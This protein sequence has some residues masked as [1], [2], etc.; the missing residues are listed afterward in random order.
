MS[1]KGKNRRNRPAHFFALGLTVFSIPAFAWGEGRALSLDFEEGTGYGRIIVGWE[2]SEADAPRINAKMTGPVLILKFEEPVSFDPEELKEGLPGYIAVARLTDDGREARVA[3]AREYRIHQ[4]YSFD[5]AGIDLVNP[6]L[7]GDPDDIVSPLAARKQR[8]AEEAAAA[9]EAARLAALPPALNVDVRA[10]EAKDFSTLAF[11]WPEDISFE[12]QDDGDAITVKFSRRGIADLAHARIDPPKG[13]TTLDAE[14]TDQQWIVRMGVEPGHWASVVKVDSAVL[15]R[16]REGEK[17]EGG[18]KEDVILPAALQ[19]LS[20]ALPE[21]PSEEDSNSILPPSRKPFQVSPLESSE[22]SEVVRT[23]TPGPKELRVNQ[24]S[25]GAEVDEAISVAPLTPRRL[26]NEAL[27]GAGKAQVTAVPHGGAVDIDISFQS[28]IPAAIFRRHKAVWIAFPASGEFD[29]SSTGSTAGLRIDQVNSEEGMA[30]RIYA[31]EDQLVSINQSGRLWSVSIGGKGNLA[32]VQLKPQRTASSGGSGILVNVP[33]IG[34][35]FDLFDPD[36]GETITAV[37]V[38]THTTSLDRSLRFVEAILPVTDQGLVIFPLADDLNVL[39][40]GEQVLISRDSGLAISNWGVDT[41]L[42][43]E[44]TLSPG[45]L[46]FAKWRRGDEGDFWR[47]HS[48]L[49]RAAALAHPEEWSGQSALMD[50]ARFYLAWG[51]A[52]ESYGPLT[53]LSEADPLLKEDAQWLALKGAADI[54][55]GRYDDALKTLDK[56]SIRSDA[57]VAAWR[58]YAFAEQGDWRK[59]REAFITADPMIDAYADIWAGRF[60]AAAARANIR[61]GDGAEAERHALAARRS[62]DEIAA[63]QAA[64]TLGEL[65]L[66]AGRKQDAASAFT[67][68]LD[69]KNGNIRVR[70]ELASINLAR[71]MGRMSDLDASDRLDTLRLR[72]RGDALELE[73]VNALVDVLFELGQFRE[74]LHLAQ[75]TTMQFPDMP[76]SRDLRI[77]MMDQFE[78]LYLDGRADDMDPIVSLALFYEFKD[79]TP[80]G[81]DGDRMIRKLANRLIAFDLLDPATELLAHQVENRNIVGAGKAKIASD[82]AAI[83]LMDDRPEEALR[84]IASTRQ[85]GIDDEVRLERRLLEAAA[86]MELNR[87]GHAIELL[88]G[89]SDQRALDLLAEVHWRSRTWGAAGRALHGTLPEAGVALTSQQAQ[90][91]LRAAI[92]YRLDGDYDGLTKLR[93]SYL[94]AMKQTSYAESFDL[95]TGTN[96]VSSVKLTDTIRTLADTSSADAFI[97]SLK[98]RFGE[99]GGMQ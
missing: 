59:S 28:E 36:V 53:L 14:N 34:T 5:L 87:F 80:I 18:A 91:A 70:A 31:P 49:D 12:E 75:S 94:G 82:L 96:E 51:L 43:S 33:D 88:D 6:V 60:H 3:L 71:E 17:P 1:L 32:N 45:F 92:A 57:A 73:I 11:Y 52:P 95:L 79:L 85:P 63:G 41:E 89:L 62:G 26:W 46:D 44:H 84:V 58:G 93:S 74:A 64:L 24:S 7:S 86:H 83:Y 55:N 37:S 65:A 8:E 69:H 40:R 76:G 54:M 72:W 38:K 66:A 78:K 97:R 67:K 23:E 15:V 4:S 39:Q 48:E 9:A 61:M 90:T 47:N 29:L 10:S 56:S 20:D 42:R 30:L 27:D 22:A 2:G 77:T 81:T 50:L 21:K 35:V 98:E 99:A 25:G 13:M 16:F 68:L 19:E